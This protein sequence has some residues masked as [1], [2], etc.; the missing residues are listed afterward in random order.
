MPWGPMSHPVPPPLQPLKVGTRSSAESWLSQPCGSSH[1]PGLGL[2]DA[3]SWRISALSDSCIGGRRTTR[4]C[5]ILLT[6]SCRGPTGSVGPFTNGGSF[7]LFMTWTS[8]RFLCCKVTG[9]LFEINTVFLGR[10]LETLSS[11]NFHPCSSTSTGV[12]FLN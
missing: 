9:F 6:A 7:D 2:S 12:S 1:P 11:P 10:H 8:A 4:G 3:S 5:H